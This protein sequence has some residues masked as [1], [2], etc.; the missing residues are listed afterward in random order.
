LT[1]AAYLYTI[2]SQLKNSKMKTPSTMS[3]EKGNESA[4]PVIKKVGDGLG[5]ISS[6]VEPGLTKREYFAAMILQGLCANSSPEIIQTSIPLAEIATRQ[7]D[8]LLKQ[9]NP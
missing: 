8:E 4:F 1:N 7:A 5:P 3:N 9:L 2:N 6:V